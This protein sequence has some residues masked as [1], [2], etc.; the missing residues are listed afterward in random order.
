MVFVPKFDVKG[1]GPIIDNIE[2]LLQDNE[3]DAI[4]AFNDGKPMD[5]TKVWRR[6][7]WFNTKFPATS[8][9][10]KRSNKIISADEGY[11]SWEHFID[12]EVELD[13]P[14]PDVLAKDVTKRILALDAILSKATKQEVL[15]GF[16]STKAGGEWME[17]SPH[18]YTYFGNAE[19]MLYRTSAAFTVKV[20]LI[21]MAHT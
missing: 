17:L 12:V 5:A 8:V 13:G 1:I 20:S 14:N 2:S 6:S 21:E 11:V 7:H 16:D 18:V 4:K 19:V 9:I 15:A 3:V 10:A